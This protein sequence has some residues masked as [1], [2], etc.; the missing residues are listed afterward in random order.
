V[1]KPWHLAA[2]KSAALKG[3]DP[4]PK[5]HGHRS[6]DAVALLCTWWHH[7]L[8]YQVGYFAGNASS[9]ISN[10]PG[11]INSLGWF[12]RSVRP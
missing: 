4:G 8:R 5:G 3:A 10:F 2:D 12:S 7:R 11:L 1:G 6:I 9:E